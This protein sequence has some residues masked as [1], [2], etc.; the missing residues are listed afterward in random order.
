MHIVRVGLF[1]LTL[2]FCIVS[3]CAARMTFGL[4]GDGT[5][6]SDSPPSSRAA[7]AAAGISSTSSSP[8][9]LSS[10]VL[11][12]SYAT[13][14]TISASIVALLY[15]T[16]IISSPLDSVLIKFPG[17]TTTR[18]GSCCPASPSRK[19]LGS[20]LSCTCPDSVEDDSVVAVADSSDDSADDKNTCSMG[21]DFMSC[22]V[23]P[24]K[25]KSSH[26]S[27]V[28]EPITPEQELLKALAE[29]EYA[30]NLCALEGSMDCSVSSACFQ[31]GLCTNPTIRPA[32]TSPHPGLQLYKPAIVSLPTP[33]QSTHLLSSLLGPSSKTTLLLRAF[34]K[35]IYKFNNISVMSSVTPAPGEEATPGK[36]VRPAPISTFT[37]VAPTETVLSGLLEVEKKDEDKDEHVLR[38][39]RQGVVEDGGA[40]EDMAATV[41]MVGEVKQ[42]AEIQPHDESPSPELQPQPQ[43]TP[44]SNKSTGIATRLNVQEV[45]AASNRGSCSC[46]GLV[47]A[48]LCFVAMGM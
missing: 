28:V 33:P 17:A 13:L 16:H 36:K 32:P 6:P 19:H 5:T 1:L 25:R 45:L 30:N 42:E 24:K 47:I 37:V 40:H 44:L 22:R 18:S 35:S 15:S 20:L 23:Q 10:S 11:S 39:R 26:R 14:S 27:A 31:L 46:L 21:D 7:A 29:G 43:Q 34:A 3:I 4:F 2:S 9:S 8:S 41:A 12:L 38:R 48:M